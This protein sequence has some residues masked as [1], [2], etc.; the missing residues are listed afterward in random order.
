MIMYYFAEDI[1][2]YTTGKMNECHV[3]AT[4]VLCISMLIFF[5]KKLYKIT[6]VRKEIAQKKNLFDKQLEEIESICK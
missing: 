5:I 4:A 3:V 1:R 2:G 6:V